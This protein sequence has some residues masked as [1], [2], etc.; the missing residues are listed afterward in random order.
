MSQSAHSD[1]TPVFISD[2]VAADGDW[3]VTAARPNTTATLANTSFA[4]GG[5]RL[6]A[7]TT[8]GT[9]DNGKTTTI[10]GTNVFDNVIS[11]VIVSTGSAEA[12]AGTKYFKTVSS[13]VCS[14]QYAGNITVGSLA[15]A[16]QAVGGGGR[17]RLKGFS[18][19]SGGTA[20]V[21]NYFNGTPESGTILFK[22]RTIGT[23][24]ATVSDNMPGE[25]VLFTDGMTVQYTVATVDMMTVFFA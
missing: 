1:V 7:V 8:A 20:G 24:N 21:I 23:D 11:E 9:S 17:I 6:L 2:E 5:A 25:G 14:A 15:G 4:S 12:V 18:V 19:V 13:V 16:A 22:S 10:T 3:I